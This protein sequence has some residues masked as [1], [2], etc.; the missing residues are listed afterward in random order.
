MLSRL[1]PFASPVDGREIT[2]WRERDRDMAAVD[3]FDTRD[4]PKGHA[5]RRGRD[6]QLKEAKDVGPEPIWR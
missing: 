1:E 5:F 4:L 6:V 3:A 2:S